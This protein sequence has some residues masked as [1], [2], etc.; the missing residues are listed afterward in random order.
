[1]IIVGV[2]SACFGWFAE[3]VLHRLAAQRVGE[4]N[5]SAKRILS[6]LVVC[7]GS[8]VCAVLASMVTEPP[9]IRWTLTC[10]AIVAWWLV[11]IDAA[12][13]RLP[14]PLVALL[15]VI[16]VGGYSL[17]VIFAQSVPADLT[18]AFLGGALLMGLFGVVALL[19]PQAIGLGD[20]KLAGAL[21]IAAGR[22]GWE[23]IMHSLLAAFILGGLFAVVLV[24]T[25]RAT[26]KER[27]AFG[28]WLVFG[29]A[30][31]IAIS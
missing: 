11:I 4:L 21:G 10:A 17:D 7:V 16:V 24:V 28:P 9:I 22:F 5:R 26:T 27:I 31:A 25:K 2:I 6:R 3:P 20:V 30:V 14:N 12:I 19:R 29:A 18:R 13:H 1:M 8:G 23:T 15:A